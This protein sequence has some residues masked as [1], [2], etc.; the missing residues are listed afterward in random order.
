M[1]AAD[2]FRELESIPNSVDDVLWPDLV[3]EFH[4]R[5]REGLEILTTACGISGQRRTSF[6]VGAGI[7]V[8]RPSRLPVAHMVI[9]SLFEEC[10]GIY[11]TLKR[12][13]P[14]LGKALGQSSYVLMENVFQHLYEHVPPSSFH[15]GRVF[16]IPHSPPRF[17]V[18]HTFLARWL[19]SDRGTVVTPN[20][21]PLIEHAWLDVTG[22]DPDQLTVIRRPDEF[23]GWDQLIHQPDVLWKL[24]GS[25][26]DP[27]SWA[28]ILSRVGFSLEDARVDFIRHLVSEH[29]VCFIGYRAADLDLF[30][31]IRETHTRRRPGGNVI[32]WV[33]Y[34]RE[35]YK[36]LGDYLQN[37]PN[38]A[39]LFEATP[40]C[41]YP[42]VTTA[43][44]LSTWLQSQCFH[45]ESVLPSTDTPIPDYNYRQWFALDLQTIGEQ[46][47]Q[48]LIGYTFRILG[49]H[50]QALTV[51]DEAAEA[52]LKDED[53]LTQADE[54][55]IRRTAQLLQESAQ[56]SWQKRDYP[57]AISKV[58]RAQKL[59]RGIGDDV[60]TEFGLISMVLDAKV[61]L[62]WTERI[63]VLVRLIRL[64]WRFKRLS[65]RK[66]PGFSPVLGQGLCIYY[67]TKVVEELLRKTLF[68]R[69]RVVRLLLIAGYG[70]GGRLIEK[71]KFLNSI[72]DVKRRQAFLWVTF[73][74]NR[75]VQEMIEAIRIAQSISQAHHKLNLDRA[76][77]LLEQ[78]DN[79]ELK[80]KLSEMID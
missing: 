65:R 72:P 30:P 43:E 47:A 32:F 70:R 18:N 19:H 17:N 5:C 62:R 57:V 33:F 2:S 74:A 63:A 8:C 38:I 20:L 31:P 13:S 14:A 29:H 78:I 37:E 71:S 21:D 22:L 25:S 50:D 75:A 7:S 48:N 67:E 9:R 15:A 66:A 51:L 36:T 76:R 79:P 58:K 60:G 69:F 80:S 41:I 77:L 73:D 16:D 44:R 46:A 56:T 49:E 27:E 39:Q 3:P 6:Y 34:F 26:D 64:H 54:L 1:S 28:I 53:H 23:Q 42:I 45:V 55:L 61:P 10:V 59:L 4:Q 40:E 11:P 35:G 24:H 12:Y 52:V 68:I